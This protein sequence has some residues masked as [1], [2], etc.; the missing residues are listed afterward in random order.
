MQLE[1]FQQKCLRLVVP[2]RLVCR[3]GA[4]RELPRRDLEGLSAPI[5][6]TVVPS[7]TAR[8]PRRSSGRSR[9]THVPTGASIFLPSTVN[10][11]RPVT[12]MYSSS[13]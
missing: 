2:L 1:S 11:A 4:E 12:T 9:K 7:S 6:S 5:A 10:V 13:W 8:A 3:D